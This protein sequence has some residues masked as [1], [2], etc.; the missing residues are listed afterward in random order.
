MPLRRAV[1]LTDVAPPEA[2]ERTLAVDMPGNPVP[3]LDANGERTFSVF[4]DHLSQRQDDQA[5]VEDI[6]LVV[7]HGTPKEARI[8]ADG[9]HMGRTPGMDSATIANTIATWLKLRLWQ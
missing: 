9:G 5:P 6:F 8:Y 7:E 2:Q 3:Y 4:I 1:V